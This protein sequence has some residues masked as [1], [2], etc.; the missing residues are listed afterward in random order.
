MLVHNYLDYWADVMPDAP[1]IED[2]HRVLSYGELQCLSNRTAH[3]LR[4]IGLEPGDRFAVLAEN[5]LEWLAI[6]FGAFKIGAVPVPI[7]YRLHPREWL[8][9]LNDSTSKAVVAQPDHSRTL[10]RVSDELTH[11][12]SLLVLGRGRG[13]WEPFLERV[14]IQPATSPDHRADDND[15]L[16][17][18][19]TSGTTGRPKGAVLSHRAIVNNLEQSRT[20]A[21]LAYH[22]RVLIVA[23]LF[24]AAA[25]VSCMSSIALGGS[26]LVRPSFDP[27]DCVRSLDERRI[28]NAQFVPAMIQA[29]LVSVPDV[30]DRQYETLERIAYGASPI[31]EQTLRDALATFRCDFAQGYGMTETTTVVT[32]LTA[33]DHRRALDGKPQLLLSCGRPVLGTEVRVLDTNGREAATGEIGEIVARG[34]QLMKG[35]WNM[36]EETA[37]AMR[38]GWMHTGDAGYRDADGY[39]YIADRV[40]DMIVSGGENVYPREIEDVLFQMAEVADAA[41]IGVPDEKWGETVK[42]VVVVRPDVEL[43]EE[44]V[45]SWCRGHLGGF[46]CPRS[47]DFVEELPRNPTG[48]VLK[49]ELRAPYWEGRTRSVG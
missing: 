41:V 25:A 12:K 34:P 31:A 36:P 33:D 44:S 21:R 45:I 20:T 22:P 7:N 40:K 24:H 17:Q 28:T 35:Y 26:I 11:T 14:D 5:C 2:D 27:A 23:P 30:R 43:T 48:K 8:N 16:Y 42:A 10:D 13:R 38:G 29:M 4:E 47:V 49:R 37:E 1:A 6:Y 19:Y 18:M 39:V 9:I 15:D 46:K 3:A 32:L